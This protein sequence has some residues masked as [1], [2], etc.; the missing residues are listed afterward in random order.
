MNE[1]GRTTQAVVRRNRAH[2]V[3]EAVWGPLTAGILTLIP[4]LIGLATGY[5]L[6]F[7]SLAPTAALQAAQ[8][9]ERSARFYN[10]VVGHLAG[11][12][13]AVLCVLLLRAGAEPTLF[14]AHH[15]FPRRVLASALAVLLTQL[16]QLSLKALH[17]PAAATVL[18]ITLGGF[19]TNAHDLS[20]LLAG[21]LIVAVAGE[22]IRQLRLLQPGQK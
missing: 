18:L 22:V 11:I 1:I 5:P 8:P 14:A 17:P 15:V 19:K 20:V 3:P 12:V 16:G 13:V 10:T 21:I 9:Q 4:G 6:L 7:P 2:A